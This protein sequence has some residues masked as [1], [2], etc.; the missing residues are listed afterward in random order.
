MAL[1]LVHG[2]ATAVERAGVLRDRSISITYQ[3]LCSWP[4]QVIESRIQVR[5]KR[6]VRV[7]PTTPPHLWDATV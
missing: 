5:L 4:D 6:L 1:R 3:Q 2:I 7:G